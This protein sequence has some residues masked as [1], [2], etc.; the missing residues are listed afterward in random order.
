MNN[1][2]IGQLPPFRGGISQYNAQMLDE[3]LKVKKFD[4]FSFN[5]IFPK[6]LY[7]GE[8]SYD[9]NQSWKAP[10][11]TDYIINLINPFNWK[12]IIRKIKNEGYENIILTWWNVV[13]YPFYLYLII[14]LK[15]AKFFV[16]SHNLSG[17]SKN[18]L[19]RAISK[20]I[21]NF[22]NIKYIFHHEYI[23]F[24]DNKYIE[25]PMPL[26]RFNLPSKSKK[27]KQL[28]LLFFGFIRGYKGVDKL[29]DFIKSS[30]LDVECIIAGE[31]WAELNSE[32]YNV[33]FINHYIPDQDLVNLVV[34]ADL[35]FFPF[36][37]ITGSG[38]LS[39]GMY[40]D[41]PIITTFNSTSKKFINHLEDGFLIENDEFGKSLKEFIEKC[42]N[43]KFLENLKS[44][45]SQRDKYLFSDFANDLLKYI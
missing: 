19:Y 1:L 45:A 38:S 33:K 26:H 4:I 37:D 14:S 2:F 35:L 9:Y 11:N 12:K 3:L 41:K 21:L 24:K 10:S 6:I 16:I 36:N 25:L 18:N 27:N 17:H 32:I 7:P 40:Y 22:K 30:D 8:S 13:H 31:N 39:L 20:K 28:T 42:K 43:K 44:N 5:T 15:E 29:I 34:N 23:N